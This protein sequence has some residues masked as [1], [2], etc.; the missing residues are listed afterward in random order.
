MCLI[1]KR[2]ARCP[3]ALSPRQQIQPRAR[4]LRSHCRASGLVLMA[5]T[6][7]AAGKGLRLG[8][9]RTSTWMSSHKEETV[10]KREG[11]STSSVCRSGGC[12]GFAGRPSQPCIQLSL[13]NIPLYPVQYALHGHEKCACADALV[14]MDATEYSPPWL[15]H[16]AQAQ[17]AMATASPCA[18]ETYPT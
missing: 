5:N 8:D 11:I 14:C 3:S 13:R 16:T 4:A 9:F 12:S 7:T 10:R 15:V 18:P 6:L 2:A 1:P 17:P